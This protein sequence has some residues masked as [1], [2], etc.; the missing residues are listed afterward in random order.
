MK[1]AKEEAVAGRE[2]PETRSGADAANPAA[3]T[4]LSELPDPVK[5]L[6]SSAESGESA[7]EPSAISPLSALRT[8]L[9]CVQDASETTPTCWL[10][11][12]AE[13][14]MPAAGG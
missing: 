9:L 10:Q 11:L 2:L 4:L 12:E 14:Q 8:R 13:C 1:E 3:Q 5:R 7:E 6:E